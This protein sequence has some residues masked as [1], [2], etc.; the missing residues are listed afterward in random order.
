[1]TTDKFQPELNIKI[2]GTQI[3]QVTE[4]IYLDHKLSCH[5]YQ[6]LA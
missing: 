5:N 2:N 3:E 1:M 4:F 6:E